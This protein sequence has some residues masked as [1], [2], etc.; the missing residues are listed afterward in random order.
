MDTV[1]TDSLVAVQAGRLFDGQRSFGASTVLI[2]GSRIVDID[3]TGATP[4]AHAEVIDLGSDVFLLPGLIDAHVHLAFDASADVV[5]G[6]DV[7]DDGQLLAQM[8]LAAH[9]ALR[10]GI[11]TVRDLG[12]RSFLALA[13]REQLDTW[14]DLGPEIVIW[15]ADHHPR[16]SL[17]LPR[18]RGQRS[19]GVAR[20]GARAR[21]ARL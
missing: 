21:R 14:V 3:A 20:R 1:K 4:P 13:L 19:A 10:A 18:R 2:G 17:P 6:I 12:D 16:W 7:V 9:R 5:A 15:S 11:T 8:A